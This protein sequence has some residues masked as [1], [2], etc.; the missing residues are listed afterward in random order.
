MEHFV[1]GEKGRIMKKKIMAFMLSLTMVAS[2]VVPAVAAEV[3]TEGTEISSE[4]ETE[5]EVVTGAEIVTETGAETDTAAETETVMKAEVLTE[6]GVETES[7]NAQDQDSDIIASGICGADM[8]DE[9]TWTLYNT[10]IMEI[11]G[12]G[13]IRNYDYSSGKYPEYYEYRSQ[14]TKVKINEGVFQIGNYAFAD[15]ENLSIVELSDSV[16]T[17]GSYAFYQCTNLKSVVRP[18]NSSFGIGESAFEGTA[19]DE[20]G[21]KECGDNFGDGWKFDSESCTLTIGDSTMLERNCNNDAP[22]KYSIRFIKKI[23]IE[24][25]ATQIGRE[26]FSHYTQLEE[27]VIPASV[28]KIESYAF[29]NTNLS[30]VTIPATVKYLEDQAFGSCKNLTTVEISDST[31]QSGRPFYGTP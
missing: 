30:S 8:G 6:T 4:T 16:S 27:V 31:Q 29:S 17:I 24:E 21:R 11:K 13:D 18:E 10:G 14:I 25:G 2:C 19:W 9:V 15:C 3:Q 26:W 20:S 28:E 12:F 5:A 1:K 7:E 23:I 22:W